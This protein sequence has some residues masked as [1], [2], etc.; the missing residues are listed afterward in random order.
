[1]TEINVGLISLGCDKNRI[2]SEIMLGNLSNY[3]NIVDDLEESDVIIINTCGFIEEAKQESIN[4]ILQMATYK[5]KKCKLL[6]ATGCLTQRY[7]EDLEELLPEVDIM[8]GVNNYDDIKK[9]IMAHFGDNKHILKCDYSDDNINSGERILTTPSYYAYLRISEGCDNNCTYC[10]IPK[11]R[12]RYRS[13]HMDKIIQEAEILASKGVKE[14][15]IVAQNTTNYGV[16]I[17]GEKT[18][19]ILMNKLSKI[20][21]IKWIRLMYC[22][23][24]EIYDKLIEEIRM[25]N[26]ICKYL[27]LPIQHVSDKILKKMNRRTSKEILLNKL[28]TLRERIPGVIIRTSLIVGFP[29]EEEEDFIEL[30]KFLKEYK[31]DHVGVF[32][33][34]KEEGTA[35]AMLPEQIA[36]NIKEERYNELMKIQQKISRKNNREKIG[37]IYNVLVEEKRK[38]EYTGRYYGF[39][40]EVDG[41]IIFNCGRMLSIGDFIDVKISDSLEYDLIGDVCDESCK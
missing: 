8:L 5:K 26:R 10:A 6:I 35:A 4:T 31:L 34:S 24:E 9:E 17:D 3:F 30:L 29:G 38:N 19:H 22:Y 15:I 27:D 7:S 20:V 14:L 40:P 16:D 21:G 33:Y 23:P 36:E 39:A 1:M 18:L 12:G 13:R 37:S 41:E 2:D 32:K 11:I 28:N 25:N